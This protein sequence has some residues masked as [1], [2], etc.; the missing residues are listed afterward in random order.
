MLASRPLV[1]LL[2]Y[3]YSLPYEDIVNHSAAAEHDT[4]ADEHRHDDRRGWVK[5]DERVQYHTWETRQ[6]IMRR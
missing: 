3:T 2:A 1:V 4:E 6:K 5:L